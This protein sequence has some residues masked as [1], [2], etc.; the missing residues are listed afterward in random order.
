M[1][2]DPGRGNWGRV[3][4]RQSFTSDGLGSIAARCRR[5]CLAMAAG[6]DPSTS[7]AAIAAAQRS[8]VAES[9]VRLGPGA[10]DTA[11]SLDACLPADVVKRRRA[12]LLRMSPGVV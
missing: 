4:G 6:L 1:D 8:A 2:A 12:E 7:P 3:M 11:V 10:S 5:V 9:L